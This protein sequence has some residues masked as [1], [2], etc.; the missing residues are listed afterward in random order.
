[1]SR[2]TVHTRSFHPDSNFGTGGL[3]YEGDHR[4]FSDAT[5]GVTSRILHFFIID[6]KNRAFTNQTALSDPSENHA[7]RWANE[8]IGDAERAGEKAAEWLDVEPG[9]DGRRMPE[10]PRVPR[11]R[12]D[13]SQPRKHPRKNLSGEISPYREDGDQFVSVT[14][15]YA[16]KNFA[17]PFAD[18]DKPKWWLGGNDA[19]WVWGGRRSDGGSDTGGGSR[20]FWQDWNGLVPDLDVTQKL[21][22][23]IARSLKKAH[24]VSVITGDGFPNCE[25]FMVD[26]AKSTLFLA[27]HIRMGTA[28]TQLPGGRALPMNRIM[29]DVDWMPGDLFGANVDIQIANDHTGD[30]SP[31]QIVKPAKMARAEWNRRNRTRDAS[32][33]LLRQVEDMVP[34]PRQT[35][36]GIR[37]YFT[38][39]TKPIPP[40]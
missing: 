23:R 22:L 18:G 27:T 5:S 10:L 29:M 24:V 30:G 3:L 1:M 25:S 40:S 8:R 19:H 11:V 15:T 13:Y 4:G 39:P 31:H 14:F 12:N 36:R 34:L 16:G 2:V 28:A 9:A 20:K 32:G 26:T 21:S 17:M 33:N 37:E 38:G 6:L 35:I 7:P